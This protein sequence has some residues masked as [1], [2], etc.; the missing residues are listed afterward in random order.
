M[1]DVLDELVVDVVS[2]LGAV[3]DDEVVAPIGQEDLDGH[4]AQQVAPL[5][6][7]AHVLEG[8]VQAAVR[9]AAA[10]IESTEA[11]VRAGGWE[12]FAHCPL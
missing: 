4:V 9:R 12:C 2:D 6:H 1:C 8:E 7:H 11:T 10:A 3:E 5:V